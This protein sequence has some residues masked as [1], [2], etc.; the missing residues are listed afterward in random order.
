[1]DFAHG[2]LMAT[3]QA[4]DAADYAQLKTL[5]APFFTKGTFNS[6]AL[7]SVIN[8]DLLAI[9]DTIETAAK[10]ENIASGSTFL[11]ISGRMLGGVEISYPKENEQIKVGT[12]FELLDKLITLHQ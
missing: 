12:I 9:I 2:G 8:S 11:E 10:A 7:D 3:K 5:L 6:D 1:M 4:V